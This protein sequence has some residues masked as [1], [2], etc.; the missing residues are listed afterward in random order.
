MENAYSAC[1]KGTSQREM[2]RIMQKSEN[3]SDVL[4]VS[5]FGQLQMVYQGSTLTEDAIH[6]EMVTK[7]LVYLLLHR[8]YAITVRELCDI[9]WSEENASDNPT[10]A[11][12]NLM[13]R[14]RNVLKKFFG[15]DVSF[16]LTKLGSYCWNQDI[17]VEMDIDRFE[18]RIRLAK[19]AV[20]DD[21]KMQYYE[22]ALALYQG[23][24][25]DNYS[26]EQ[27]I[28]SVSAFY[29]SMFL[30]ATKALA[31]LYEKKQRYEDMER[32][33]AK[34]I[35]FESLDEELYCIHLR[36]LVHQDKQSLALEYYEK[37]VKYFY[38]SVGMSELKK[39]KEVHKDILA[40]K[41]VSEA[42]GIEEISLD[43]QE[44]EIPEGAYVCGY[45][46]FQEL[47]RIEARRIGRMGMSEY[48]LLLTISMR[49]KGNVLESAER[50][51]LNRVMDRM[52]HILRTSL[53]VG[54]VAAR[55]SD[56]QYI[57]LLPTCTYESAKMIADRMIRQFE[58]DVKNQKYKVE[59]NIEELAAAERGIMK[60][61]EKRNGK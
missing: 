49:Q 20:D 25:L 14:L 35:R 23:Q 4:D 52:E 2:G 6:S 55:Y 61:K 45:V 12:K 50:Y 39:L 53:R 36:A 57:V 29:H 28:V 19:D 7:L 3:Q 17:S 15:A 43:I 47:C 18:N 26:S 27:W 34:A 37:T 51:M 56:S 42:A 32:I 11:L 31:E 54:D 1:V 22:D 8:E 41:K 24:F 30:N 58:S 44:D 21:E 13:Y 10:G 40:M 5:L 59:Y 60:N 9:L 33:S 48:I 16:V 38:D 46:V